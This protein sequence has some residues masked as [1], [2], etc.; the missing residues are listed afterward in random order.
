MHL[1]PSPLPLVAIT[2]I[3]LSATFATAENSSQYS[4]YRSQNNARSWSR[5]D[6]G[7]PPDS[8][9]NALAASGQNF[10]AGTDAGIFIST[11]SAKSW[12]RSALQIGPTPRIT[13]LVSHGNQLYAGSANGFLLVSS[14][15]GA[16]WQ[17]NPSFPNIN[18]RSLQSLDGSLYVGTDADH[19]YQSPDRGQTWTQLSAGLPPHAQIFALTSLNGRLLAGLYA[20]GLF[21][22]NHTNQKWDR[23]G[24][25]AHISPL[26]LAT[27]SG[28]I[29]A[30]HNPGGIYLSD[31]LGHTWTHWSLS[32]TPSA[33]PATGTSTFSLLESL[34]TQTSR[35]SV[36]AIE[37]PVWEMSASPN[38]AI[39]GAGSGIYYS[40]DRVRTW[41]RA[42]AGLPAQ[43][44]GI[45]FLIHE[46]LILAALQ[47]KPDCATN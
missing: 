39:A 21:A 28:T 1:R 7:L 46:N 36:P 42:T 2:L 26:A 27:T 40:T 32:D 24:A 20:Q 41:T 9:I 45:A 14:D 35:G 31:D 15:D 44:S 22:W 16:T 8:R 5:S 13:S 29:I 17:R 3:I 43:S 6:A 10:I 19:V 18:I 23:L 33:P 34:T 30:G 25:A 4:L 37:A 47:H 11:N 38:L 12:Q